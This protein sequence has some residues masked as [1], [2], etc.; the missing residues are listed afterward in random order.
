MRLVVLP[1]LL[2]LA[3]LAACSRGGSG[4]SAPAVNIEATAAATATATVPAG[5]VVIDAMWAG[6]LRKVAEFKVETPQRLVWAEGGTL[7][8]LT[9]DAVYAYDPATR[10]LTAA[11]TAPSPQRV[12]A[13]SPGGIVAVAGSGYVTAVR[14][15]DLASG[16]IVRT[17]GPGG[18]TTS[19][20]FFDGGKR[21]LL[22][23]GDRIGASMWDVATGARLRDLTGFQT[24]APVFNVTIAEGG[25]HA[26]WVA[27][28]TFQF[29]DTTTGTFGMRAQF[30]DFIGSS[31][32][33]PRGD[34]FA[35]A[36]A[37]RGA[38][39][40]EGIV[41]VWD[42]ATGA[43]RLRITQEALPAVVAFAPSTPLIAVGDAGF[44]LWDIEDAA[45]PRQLAGFGVDA[46]GLV[47]LIAFSPDGVTVATGD[48]E[49]NIRLWRA[50]P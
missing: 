44:S 39:G 28:A 27:R 42:P 35:T 17:I 32:F 10:A 15:V 9:L 41:Q 2:A 46:A 19:A 37:G 31:A 3:L 6:Q 43:E 16:D 45:K 47:R 29:Q 8:V 25:T 50:V 12:L 33:S 34:V 14:L 24:A 40:L 1:L 48:N 30:E 38:N 22:T 36:R 13:V 5:P 21:L 20:T 4:S 26:A 49:G 23:S 18:I 7:R 11:Y